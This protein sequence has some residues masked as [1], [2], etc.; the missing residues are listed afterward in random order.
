MNMPTISPAVRLS[1][2]LVL[3]SL[4]VLLVADLVGLIPKKTEIILDARKKVCESLAV[5]LSVA[6]TKSDLELLDSTLESFVDRNQDVLAA[7]MNR[8]NGEVVAE[9]G[10]FQN[11]DYNS[12]TAERSS[13]NL[14][15][16]PVYAGAERW[17]SVN[18]E[19]TAITASVVELLS[20]SILG[21]LLFVAVASITGYIIILRKALHVLDPKAV[22]PER[23][24]S[25][26][27]ALAE[28]V[29]I[30]DNKEQIMMANDAFAKQLAREPE[31]LVGTRASSLKWKFRKTEEDKRLPWL[32]SIDG[33]IQKI[34]VALNLST[35]HQGV[36]SM[37]TNSAPIVDDVGK[38][39]G[40]LV[41]FDDITDVEESNILLESA[42]STLQKN[43]AEIRRKNRELEVLAS[44]D[45]LTG[46]Y[47]RRALFDIVE[48]MFRQAA[49]TNTDMVCIMVDIDHFKSINDR[50]GHAVGDE[51][52]RMVSNILNACEHEGVVV[53]RYGGEEFC[54]ALP[55]TDL[56][57]GQVVA[58]TLRN[59]IKT[60]SVTFSDQ[61]VMLTA[62]FGVADARAEMTSIS[63]LLE[64]ADEALYKA[65]QS[66]RDRVVGWMKSG[67]GQTDAAA[68]QPDNTE[69]STADEN[70]GDHDGE[71]SVDV[72]SLNRTIRQL[73][74]ELDA[75]QAEAAKN[76]F[77][78]P[79]TDLPTRFIFE[80]RI[81]QAIAYAA[82]DQ[83]MLAVV[84]LNVDM[85][86]R[87]NNTLGQDIGDEFLKT[88]GQRLKTILRRSDTVASMMAPGLAGPSLSRLHDDEFAILLTGL[89]D[90]ESLTYIIKRI[91]KKFS[92]K[93]T[94][95]DNMLYVTT[96]IGVSLFPND[97]VTSTVLIENARSAQKHA[98]SLVGKNNYHFFSK[99][100]NDK[101]VEQLQLE[102]DLHNAIES[103]QFRLVYQPKINT[104][105]ECIESME[106][107]IRWYHPQRGLISPI[108]FIP[109]A[110]KTG[111]VVDIGKWCLNAVCEQAS[112]WV[113]KGATDLRVSV[114]I[115]AIE[116]SDESFIDSVKQALKQ[117][118]LDAAH[119]ELE[120]TETTVMS[121]IEKS[122]EIIDE[123]RFIGVTMTMDDFGAGYSSFKYLGHLNFDWIKIDRNFLLDATRHSRSK[124]LYDGM[125]A[126]AHEIGLK[127]VAEGIE[128]QIE[129][130]YVNRIGVDEMQGNLLSKPLD[131]D[132][133]TV[134]LF[135]DTA[136][137]SKTG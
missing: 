130:N 137:Q 62:S 16:V 74:A 72:Q 87:I 104:R 121:D 79:V 55:D 39:R 110:E 76:K 66:G 58:E 127:V 64:N 26:F 14:V 15:L 50:F 99:E 5:Q 49:R 118:K 69:N 63:Q 38:T 12:K 129:Y 32:N 136:R 106:T 81:S 56:A 108:T 116:F 47:N 18:V 102:V 44:R 22:V 86:S 60:A 65:K 92:G 46:C 131:V 43:D 41:T 117:N 11:A 42:V 71:G 75:N 59:S 133:M 80:D 34:G 31:A 107:L 95:A 53:G 100:I 125:V 7:S 123:L 54:V 21:L 52:I 97:G 89:D 93:I 134:A 84:I 68:G 91:Q 96:T 126:M 70:H 8:V 120:V 78:D 111:L 10:I 83:S 3:F 135:S 28:G 61:D 103:D 85:F 6:A 9:H 45:A 4:S 94:V 23:V 90:I 33:G 82:R 88:V 105:S 35:P 114:N 2:G 48:E 109:T 77:N 51:A 29:L 115:S 13:D 67:D 17:G 101:I 128:N 98:K 124:T 19:F 113:R 112:K 24:R 1:F 73:R 37:S 30:L 25:A 36:R 119:L 27:N 40:A 57:T 132:A 20:E 122:A